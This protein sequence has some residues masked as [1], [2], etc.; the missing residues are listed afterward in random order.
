MVGRWSSL[1]RLGR[2]AAHRDHGLLRSVASWVEGGIE[3]VMSARGTQ[4]CLDDLAD[5]SYLAVDLAVHEKSD[6]HRE[7]LPSAQKAC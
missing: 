6:C 1:L 7:S 5:S 3:P 2:S 4:A